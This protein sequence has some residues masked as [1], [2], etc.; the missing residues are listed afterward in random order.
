MKELLYFLLFFAR[1]SFQMKKLLSAVF[2]VVVIISF[3]SV[4][5]SARTFLSIAT[6]STGGT[7]YPLGG[8]IAEIISRNV[9]DFQVILRD[10]QTLPRRIS[11]SSEPARSRWL[12]PKT[13]SPTGRRREW[14]PLRKG[15]TTYASWRLSTRACPLHHPER[16]RR[17]RHHGHK[18]QEGVRRRPRLGSPR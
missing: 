11:T 12:S 1:G 16:K 7:Y 18:G 4:P 5:A 10:G 14:L 9:P 15:T 13:T 6:G 3:L 8:G 17:K 2:T